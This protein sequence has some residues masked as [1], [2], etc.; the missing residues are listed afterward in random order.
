MRRG[1]AKGKA[2]GHLR[3][4]GRIL[5]TRLFILNLSRRPACRVGQARMFNAHHGGA[6]IVGSLAAYFFTIYSC[7]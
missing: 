5:I 1:F 4:G 7:V 6:G 2:P 3:G